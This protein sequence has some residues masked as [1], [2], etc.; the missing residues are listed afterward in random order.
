MALESENKI[1]TLKS[2]HYSRERTD[3]DRR[4]KEAFVKDVT[5]YIFH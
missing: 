1:L 4:V 5:G 3:G 2:G